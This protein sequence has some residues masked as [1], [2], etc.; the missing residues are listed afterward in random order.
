MALA[1]ALDLERAM[2]MAMAMAMA[3]AM[4]LALALATAMAMALAMAL[5]LALALALATAMAMALDLAMAMALDL[6]MA[7]AMAMAMDNHI[8]LNLTKGLKNMSD[9]L[10]YPAWVVVEDNCVLSIT[11]LSVDL[12]NGGL[13]K[14]Q[15]DPRYRDY[16]HSVEA[17]VRE[18]REAVKW[19]DEKLTGLIFDQHNCDPRTFFS[20]KGELIAAIPARTPNWVPD[21]CDIA[22]K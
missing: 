6:A 2:A 7:M 4:A 17:E 5:A 13:I 3:L 19:F 16:I 15:I 1:M 20:K 21:C 10:I 11:A 14:S 8:K 12:S 22:I 18:L 9:D